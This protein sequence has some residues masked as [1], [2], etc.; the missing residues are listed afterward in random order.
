M[1][2]FSFACAAVCLTLVATPVTAANIIP[3]HVGTYTVTGVD[4]TLRAGSPWGP[5]SVASDKTQVADGVFAAA[6]SQWNSS[7]FWWD[8]DPSVNASPVSLE[9]LLDATY[10]I[11]RF[12]VQADDNDSY[13]LEFWDG[14][15]WQLAWTIPAVFTFGYETRDSGLLASISTD[16]LRFTATS[17]DN[18]YSVNEIQAFGPEV[19]PEPATL[20]LLG[21]G[22]I[23]LGAARRPRR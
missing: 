15:A 1:T 6:N 3:G 20:S 4:G 5:G 19:V 16:R 18:Y 11:N 13:T 22:L 10:E 12:V 17:G 8:Q 7:G 2:Q 23:G 21:L 9:L 14:S